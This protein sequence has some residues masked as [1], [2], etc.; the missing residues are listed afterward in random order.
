MNSLTFIHCA[1]LHIDR[2]F[3][4][5]QSSLPDSLYNLV[6]KGSAISFTRIVDEAIKREVDFV[7]ISGD[8]FDAEK[9]RIQGQLHVR[10]EL[11]RLHEAKIPAYIIHGNHDP[12]HEQIQSLNMPENVHV[13]PPESDVF[14]Y[15][16]GD[17]VRAY[18]YGFSYQSRS[19]TDDPLVYYKKVEDLNGY[20]IAL[21][22]GQER[23]Q[24]GH[25][26]YASFDLSALYSLNMDYW[27]LGHIH[28]RQELSTSPPVVYPG[29][30]QGGHRNEQGEKGA[31]AVALSR[32]DAELHF[33]ETAPVVWET[34]YVPIDDLTTVEAWI[35]RCQ[36]MLKPFVDAEKTYIVTVIA[37]GR[38]DLHRELVDEHGR[39]SLREALNEAYDEDEPSIWIDRIET[40]TGLHIDRESLR[41]GDDFAAD[42]VRL[43][44]ER[45]TNLDQV[46]E[47][48]RPLYQHRLGR[49][50]VS[51]FTNEEKREILQQ[52]EQLILSALYEEGRS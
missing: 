12:L 38:G 20:H 11:N 46:D 25:D 30:I 26:P 17:G 47:L 2:P 50:Y 1:D 35:D 21:L 15:E 37:H 36:Q 51:T 23:T 24:T 18:M 9:R 3:K 31:Y 27:A 40:Q 22:H 42:I 19:F 32:D 52:A 13:F 49:K 48:Y 45:L 34:C 7:V 41:E 28:K 6:K 29:N 44:D 39:Q 43:N 8:L 4:G 5:L 14:V 16:R 33:I 10:N